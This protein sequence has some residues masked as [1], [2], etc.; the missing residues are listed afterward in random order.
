MTTSVKSKRKRGGCTKPQPSQPTDA[1]DKV[2]KDFISSSESSVSLPDLNPW[3][4][5]WIHIR[6]EQAN[7]RSVSV[8]SAGKI[9]T[10]TLTKPSDWKLPETPEKTRREVEAD[11]RVVEADKEDALFQIYCKY[12]AWGYDCPDEMIDGEPGLAMVAGI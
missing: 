4:R 2:F 8:E 6:S 7:I 3:D 10:M 1:L 11:F 12:R 5:K 9:K